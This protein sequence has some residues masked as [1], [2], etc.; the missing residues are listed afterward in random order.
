MK[1]ALSILVLALLLAPPVHADAA[2]DAAAA[3]AADAPAAPLQLAAA[4]P[5]AAPAAPAVAVPATKP[6]TVSEKRIYITRVGEDGVPL[7]PLP[8]VPAMPPLPPLPP[9]PE[10]ISVQLAGMPLGDGDT[11][12]FV[13]QEFGPAAA[14]VKGAPYSAEATSEKV[15]VLADG[16]RIVRR[17]LSRLYRD[18]QGR[19]RQELLAED[20]KVRSVF[21]YDPQ[22][23]VH[24]LIDPARRFASKLSVPAVP[25]V[26][27]VD[28]G[29]EIQAGG[30]TVRIERH[31]VS[32]RDEQG[33]ETRIDTGSGGEAPAD[34]ERKSLGSREIEGVK[35]EGSQSRRVI[36]AGRI[37]NEKPIEIVSERW[38]SPELKVV[39]LTRTRDPRSGESS[40]ALSK[41]RRAEP[42]AGLFKPP[43]DYMV[44][45][46][47]KLPPIPPVPRCRRSRRWPRCRRSHRPHLPHPG[48]RRSKDCGDARRGFS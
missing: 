22:A 47:A 15:Q 6:R 3:T 27:V 4:A 21:V 32:V 5:T 31:V 48:R 24:Y 10:T 16:N 40:Y 23:G 11:L 19:T 26:A 20:G 35:A 28:G 8:A 34:G 12:A 37:G 7:P 41:I 2:A 42:D 44:R 29:R 30:K 36:A 17:T 45:D 1:P 38:Y 39:L 33:N 18:G 46:L 13:G 43:A 14:R 9:I 25:P